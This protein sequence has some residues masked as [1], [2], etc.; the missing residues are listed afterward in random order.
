MAAPD[1]L[2]R[3]PMVPHESLRD[4]VRVV[5][6][7]GVLRAPLPMLRVVP[8]AELRTPHC[9]ATAFCAHPPERP[10]PVIKPPLPQDFDAL[11]RGFDDP[12]GLGVAFRYVLGHAVDSVRRSYLAQPGN[13]PSR[14]LEQPAAV[15]SLAAGC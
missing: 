10:G 7:D 12:A 4:A 15:P 1:L 5:A 6:S 8:P 3:R 11:R 9:A 13:R 2:H 14:T